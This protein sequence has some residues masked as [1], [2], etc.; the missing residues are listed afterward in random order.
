MK[1]LLTGSNGF[2]GGNLKN[3]Y[4]KKPYI[5]H[6]YN[7][8]KSFD[9]ILKGNKKFDLIINTASATPKNCDN[10]LIIESNIINIIKSFN[11]NF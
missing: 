4:I 6:L 11:Y 10:K 5:L 8:Q 9:E 7:R 2:L 1:V 3:L